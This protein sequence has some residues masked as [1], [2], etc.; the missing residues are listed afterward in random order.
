LRSSIQQESQNSLAIMSIESE[1]STGLNMDEILRELL[2]LQH[3]KKFLL[4][5]A[6]LY[7]RLP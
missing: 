7:R 3:E 6:F 4:A 5:K 2:I 1:I